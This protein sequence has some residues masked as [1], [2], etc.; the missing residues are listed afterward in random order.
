MTR[1]EFRMR[2]VDFAPATPGWRMLVE[3]AL[4]EESAS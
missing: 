2:V 1:N 3:A 4:L